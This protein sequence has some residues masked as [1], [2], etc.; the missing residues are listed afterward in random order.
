[1]DRHLPHLGNT[2]LKRLASTQPYGED[3]LARKVCAL[4]APETR[5]LEAAIVGVGESERGHRASRALPGI[6]P[7]LGGD[8]G[9]IGDVTLVAA[10][11]WLR[12]LAGLTATA[13]VQIPGSAAGTSAR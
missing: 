2:R 5:M 13:L 11:A 9:E 12:S 3:G 4:L 8:H 10:P 7:V 6:G 1:M